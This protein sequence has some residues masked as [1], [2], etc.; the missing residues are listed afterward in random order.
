MP[1]GT[2]IVDKWKLRAPLL[3]VR[4]APQVRPRYIVIGHHDEGGGIIAPGEPA[5]E[6]DRQIRTAA[7]T[8]SRK[9]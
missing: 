3:E 6:P 9:P 1:S 8:S 5:K 4:L 2:W 7:D